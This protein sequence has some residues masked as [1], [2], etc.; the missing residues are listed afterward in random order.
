ME[1]DVV[2]PPNFVSSFTLVFKPGGSSFAS[3]C[4]VL[5][6]DCFFRSRVWSSDSFS[7]SACVKKNCSSSATSEEVVVASMC[8]V[9]IPSRPL[10]R[11]FSV[12]LISSPEVKSA[13]MLTEPVKCAIWKLK[14]NTQSH[15]IHS[16]G[17]IAFV[18]KKRVT[19]LLS[20]GTI[21]GFVV[22]HKKCAN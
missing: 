14:C 4:F 10:G 3:N 22:S 17:G 12:T 8:G 19:D 9:W 6:R 1:Y 5:F 15:A 20:V 2:F 16:A 7:L 13:S 18:W 21:V 11:I